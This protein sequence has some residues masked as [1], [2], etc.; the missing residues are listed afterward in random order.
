LKLICPPILDYK[1]ELLKAEKPACS[2]ERIRLDLSDAEMRRS[3]FGSL[4]RSAAKALVITEGLLVY[5]RAQEV[6]ALAEDLMRSP[7]F[8]RWVLDIAS[9]GLLR[10]LQKNTNQQFSRDVSPLQFARRT[11]QTFSPAVAGR[12]SKCTRY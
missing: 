11:A 5:L 4:A 1:E 10:M 2:L 12:L 8:K 9:Q 3:L 6:M 7:A